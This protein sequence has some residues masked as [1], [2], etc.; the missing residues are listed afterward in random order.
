MNINSLTGYYSISTKK[1]AEQMIDKNM[2]SFVGTDCHHVG[3]INLM[4]D[5]VYDPYLQKLVESGTLLNQ[6]L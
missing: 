4:K 1:I 3:H 6:T 5:V 2:I